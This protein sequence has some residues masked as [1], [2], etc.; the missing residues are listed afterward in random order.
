VFARY[1]APL[2]FFD[3]VFRCAV[4]EAKIQAAASTFAGLMGAT[5]KPDQVADELLSLMSRT[6]EWTAEELAELRRRVLPATLPDS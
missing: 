5:D 3:L 1:D 2:V 6:A 4:N